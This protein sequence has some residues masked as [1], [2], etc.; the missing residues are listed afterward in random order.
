MAG[1]NIP[2]PDT[3]H[4]EYAVQ[5]GDSGISGPLNTNETVRSYRYL[6]TIEGTSQSEN[7]PDF[8]FY[9]LK[10]QRPEFE[11]DVI[12][13]FNGSDEIYIPG[14]YRWSKISLDYYAIVNDDNNRPIDIVSKYFSEWVYGIRPPDGIRAASIGGTTRSVYDIYHSLQ[15]A[16]PARKFRTITIETLNGQSVTISKYKCLQAWP[17][18]LVPSNLSYEDNSIAKVTVELRFNKC[19]EEHS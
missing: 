13:V 12:T 3:C 19:L 7:E 1:F 4:D 2:L 8:K 9:A 14:K 11:S 10:C 18:K 6:V 17:I 16:N 5:T 15:T